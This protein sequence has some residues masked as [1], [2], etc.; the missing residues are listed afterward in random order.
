MRTLANSFLFKLGPK[1]EKLPGSTEARKELVTLA[2]EY[3]DSLFAEASDDLE[4]QRELAAAYE[5]V[6]DV[7]GNPL[8][9]NIG[10]IKGALVSYEKALNIR[11]KLFENEPENPAY[12]NELALNY[13]ALGEIHSNGSDYEKGKIFIDKALELREKT[14]ARNPQD[15][16]A[17]TRLAEIISSRGDISFYEYKNKEAIEYYITREGD[18]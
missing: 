2:L 8:N 14:L 17:R 3:L 13:K 18:L 12:K 15:F 16:E 4:L 9:P 1:I 5:K 6:G 10:D 7:Q 11:Q